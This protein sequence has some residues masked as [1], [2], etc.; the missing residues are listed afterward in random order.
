MIQKN[1]PK[2]SIDPREVIEREGVDALAEL[3]A[4]AGYVIQ[5]RILIDLAHALRSRKPLLVEG[6]RGGGKTALAESLAQGCNLTSFY[7][8]GMDDLNIADVLY[9]WDREAQTHMV[10]QEL[11]AGT[12]L[13]DAQARQFS[14]E[15][16]IL[17]E[18]LAAFDYAD[19]YFDPPV[20]ILDEADKLTEKIE[21]MLLQLL[22][23]FNKN[24]NGDPFWPQAETALMTSLLLHLSQIAHNPTPAMIAEFI[25][26]RGFDEI[27]HEMK[28]SP[29]PEAQV[30]WGIFK[31]ADREKTQ[32]GVFVGLGTKLA[33][34]RSPHAMAVM[35]SVTVEERERGLREIDLYRL[36]D[37]GTGVYVIIQEGDANRYRI[38]LSILF[39]LAASITRKTSDNENGAPVLLAL[40]EAGN[41]PLHNLSEALGVGRG[42]RCGIVLGYQNIGQLYKQ[43]G[44]DG[45][46]AILG[47]IGTMLFLPGL[48]SETAQYAAKRIGRTTVLQHSVVDATGDVYDQDRLSETGRD[49]LD[50]AELRQ[51][52]E[53]TQAVAIIGSAPPARFGFPHCAKGG[54]LAHPL[55]REIA[56]P[57]SLAD[58][59]A[60]VANHR[61]EETET[62]QDELPTSEVSPT[63][64]LDGDHIEEDEEVIPQDPILFPLIEERQLGDSHSTSSNSEWPATTNAGLE[65]IN[66][67]A[68]A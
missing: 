24:Y 55:P 52:A 65:R 41:I 8:Q 17:G 67:E 36:R 9:S 51:M 25:A 7:L 19:K 62:A 66:E 4:S 20:L 16:L 37:P 31:K 39:G 57:V 68:R 40:D 1:F 45:A 11:A 6:P 50:A 42:R 10:R 47:S 63:S 21:D 61:T 5:R 29:D 3:L 60:T 54:P 32:G 33:P 56:Q 43:H 27:N 53:H 2:P 46:Q 64:D 12:L 15:Y 38:V 13:R 58:A 22:G 49:L 14:R 26:A 18:A 48:D 28:A 23:R 35:Q 44:R 30:Q 59:E 34:L